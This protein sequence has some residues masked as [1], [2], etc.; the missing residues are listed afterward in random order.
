MKPRRVFVTLELTTDCSLSR[1][2]DYD[3]WRTLFN[4]QGADPV[5]WCDKASRMYI[6]VEQVQVN[7]AKPAAKKQPR[8]KK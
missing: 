6:G 5:H 7:V 4:T 1:L 2:R 8:R 3:S